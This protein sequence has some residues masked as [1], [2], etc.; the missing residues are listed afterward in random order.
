MD[1]VVL[2]CRGELFRHEP[3]RATVLPCRSLAIHRARARLGCITYEPYRLLGRW[4]YRFYNRSLVT[5]L[6]DHIEANLMK[7]AP[8]EW[9]SIL[10]HSQKWPGVRGDIGQEI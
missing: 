6:L 3:S 7:E 1:G 8:V 10:C 9:R 2:L 5:Y 4:L